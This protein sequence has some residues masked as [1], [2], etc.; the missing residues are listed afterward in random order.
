MNE[1][2]PLL[3]TVVLTLLGG[4]GV[5]L[6]R[7]E[8]RSKGATAEL[9][10]NEAAEKIKELSLGLLEP[11]ERKI[12]DLRAENERLTCEV[13]GLRKKLEQYIKDEAVYQAELHAKDQRIKELESKL[14][15]ARSERVDLK[16]RV[17]HLEDVCKRAGI[18]GPGVDDRRNK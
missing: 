15:A 5:W 1:Y 9:T 18:N 7:A 16:S 6:W 12:D 8:K 2:L 13:E 11:L 3:N 4:G 17:E 10:E 14:L